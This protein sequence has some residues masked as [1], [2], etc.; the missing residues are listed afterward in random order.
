MKYGQLQECY[1]DCSIRKYLTVILEYV[2]VLKRAHEISVSF[3]LLNVLFTIAHSFCAMVL[4]FY[5][6]AKSE[7]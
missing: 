6:I 3:M 2:K 5:G 4:C 7:G 1:T